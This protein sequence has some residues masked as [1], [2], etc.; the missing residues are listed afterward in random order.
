M[1]KKVYIATVQLVIDEVKNEAEAADAITAMLSEY[2]WESLLD[3]AY[4]KMGG[5]YM[6]PTPKLV[7]DDYQEGDFL[8]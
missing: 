6:T 4:L 8:E 7:R 2:P 3:W 1:A 5:Q